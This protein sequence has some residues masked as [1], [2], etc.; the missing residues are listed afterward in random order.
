M[1]KINN[2][3]DFFEQSSWEFFLKLVSYYFKHPIVSGLEQMLDLIT[4]SQNNLSSTHRI[5]MEG[6]EKC[7]QA[8]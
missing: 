8:N 2:E 7:R 4:E 5:S 6:A 1:F 3:L